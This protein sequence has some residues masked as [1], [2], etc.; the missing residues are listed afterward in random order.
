MDKSSYKQNHSGVSPYQKVFKIFPV[1]QHLMRIIT[2]RMMFREEVINTAATSLM[3]RAEWNL[4]D[5]NS[6][7]IST[8]PKFSHLLKSNHKNLLIF[9][10][11]MIQ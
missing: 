5:K 4:P 6:E 7:V 11:G 1:V 8:M 9:L 3:F 2:E 10:E